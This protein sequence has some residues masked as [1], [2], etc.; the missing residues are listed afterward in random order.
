MPPL[1][2]AA[3]EGPKPVD[4]GDS[5]VTALRAVLEVS[6]WYDPENRQLLAEFRAL[7]SA[8]LRGEDGKDQEMRAKAREIAARGMELEQVVRSELQQY[9]RQKEQVAKAK[10]AKA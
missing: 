10:T 4:K 3:Y 2:K 1:S 9:E 8:A 5:F 7:R 6:D